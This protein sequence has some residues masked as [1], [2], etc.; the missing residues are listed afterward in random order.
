LYAIEG[1]AY[2]E[3]S[4]LFDT[5]EFE[6]NLADDKHR[7]YPD[8]PNCV[9]PDSY[10]RLLSGGRDDCN[11]INPGEEDSEILTLPF[12]ALLGWT[13]VILAVA[14]SHRFYGY[15]QM[16]QSLGRVAPRVV[17]IGAADPRVMTRRRLKRSSSRGRSPRHR[18]RRYAG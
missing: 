5:R 15:W 13:L 8:P 9:F 1:D 12:L 3:A 11:T 7:L 10:L 2:R 16:R 18:R 17:A 6:L 14:A 4:R